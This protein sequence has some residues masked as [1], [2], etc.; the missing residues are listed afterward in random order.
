MFRPKRFAPCNESLDKQ[1]P[2]CELALNNGMA[3]DRNSIRS[4]LR[5]SDFDRVPDKGI[6]ILQLGDVQIRTDSGDE[7]EKKNSRRHDNDEERIDQALRALRPKPAQSAIRTQER[8]C[9]NVELSHSRS[10]ESIVTAPP[11][12]VDIL[13]LLKMVTDTENSL[14]MADRETIRK[15]ARSST[16][17]E[18][19]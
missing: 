11:P 16:D 1:N 19:Q 3:I 14:P 4:H 17:G 5:P 9:N 6:C 8:E 2:R 18:T 12:E 15:I 13:Q 10:D 7:N